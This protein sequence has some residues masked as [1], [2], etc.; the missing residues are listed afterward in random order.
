MII[1]RVVVRIVVGTTIRR[2]KHERGGRLIV[3]D[4]HRRSNCWVQGLCVVVFPTSLL[5]NRQEEEKTEAWTEG[6]VAFH[7]MF[8][9][10]VYGTL[11]MINILLFVL[12]W[13]FSSRLVSG[14]Y[15]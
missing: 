4:I 3:S 11:C 10:C 15:L 7:L 1:V 8:V 6:M 14:F 2:A 13:I 5:F 9:C 12:V